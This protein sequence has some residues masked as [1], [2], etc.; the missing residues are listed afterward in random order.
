M[1]SASVEAIY[2]N[3]GLDVSDSRVTE[4]E[5]PWETYEETTEKLGG[6]IDK[7]R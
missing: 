1:S 3:D 2:L 6:E 5:D 7:V 4:S